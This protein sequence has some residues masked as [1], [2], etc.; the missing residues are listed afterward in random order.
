MGRTRRARRQ[1]SVARFDT[2]VVVWLHAADPR[3]SEAALEALDA[4]TPVISPV[5]ALELQYLHEVGRIRPIGAE[6]IADLEARVELRL[7]DVPFDRVVASAIDL[8]WTPDPFDRLIV[9][10]AIAAGEPLVTAD[11]II[12]EHFSGARW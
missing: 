6:V 11:R 2:H 8:A 7:S 10:D 9:A 1:L 3:L 4:S 5:V 12:R